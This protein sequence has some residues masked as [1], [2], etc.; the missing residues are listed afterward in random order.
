MSQGEL[1]RTN[2]DG[3][4]RRCQRRRRSRGFTLIELTVAMLAGLLV[5]M[6]LVQ[7]SKEANNTFHEEVR[8]AA[9]QMSLR[10]A[11]ERLRND[12]MQV[13]YMSTGNIQGDPNIAKLV[14]IANPLGNLLAPVPALNRLAGIQLQFGGSTATAPL[15][16]NA[17][18]ALNPDSIDLGGNYSSPDEFVGYMCP[19]LGGGCGGQSICLDW[20]NS[21]ATWRIRLAS[22]PA[23][24]L[25][26][27]FN[28]S[29]FNANPAPG[30]TNYMAR[31][32]YADT[33][34]YN[35]LLTCPGLNTTTYTAN[36][37]SVNIAPASQILSTLQT[38]GHG[39]V[40]GLGVAQV[41]ISP[42]EIVHWQIQQAAAIPGGPNAFGATIAPID[43]NEY[44]LTRSYVDALN[45]LPDPTT[46]EV[47]SEYAVDLK[48]AFT[49]DNQIP[50]TNP[51]GTFTTNPFLYLQLDNPANAA[52][53]PNVAL[54]PFNDQGPHRIRSA[55]V[56]VAIRTVFPDRTAN[57]KPVPNTAQPYLYRYFIPGTAN[58]LQWARVRTGVTET[59]L[60]NQARL[61][62]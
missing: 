36:G 51:A 40:G 56:R 28:P 35:Y 1:L 7:V 14:G 5:A 32:T 15:S 53:A 41:I 34:Y 55:R 60:P 3:G 50:V 18:N 4:R 10:V 47:V 61:F 45:N 21:P 30:A 9:A 20:K 12:L 42:V 26:S 54:A 17:N 29:Y 8:A 49:V 19:G 24:T 25:Q 38:G 59:A 46:L 16:I 52:W 6:A 33:G 44:V 23:Q 2:R 37:A 62:W 39:G 13:A 57:V 11:M 31:I 43:P 48:F 58:G 22:N 27:Y